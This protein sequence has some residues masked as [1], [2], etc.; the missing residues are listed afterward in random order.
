MLVSQLPFTWGHDRCTIDIKWKERQQN[1]A[2]FKLQMM[3]GYHVGNFFL[4]QI[5]SGADYVISFTTDDIS[6]ESSTYIGKLRQVDF[7]WLNE[8]TVTQ[9][10]GAECLIANMANNVVVKSIEQCRVFTKLTRLHQNLSEDWISHGI[11]DR[12]RQPVTDK[13]REDKGTLIVVEPEITH[14]ADLKRTHCNKTNEFIVHT[15]SQ[16]LAAN[17]QITLAAYKLLTESIHHEMP[18]QIASVEEQ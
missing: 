14:V 6:E 5:D 13:I 10:H 1:P 16:I 15:E 9:N 3:V 2:I 17:K 11:E 7:E 8:L 4:L 12:R 18:Q